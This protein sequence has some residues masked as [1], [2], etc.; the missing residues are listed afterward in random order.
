MWNRRQNF[1]ILEIKHKHKKLKHKKK[2]QRKKTF[3][4]VSRLP[5]SLFGCI[6][7]SLENSF[8]S[9]LPLVPWGWGWWRKDVWK[10]P[11]YNI[12]GWSS[13]VREANDSSFFILLFILC[14]SIG[15]KSGHTPCLQGNKPHLGLELCSESMGRENYLLDTLHTN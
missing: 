3:K 11:S 8:L 5:E 1:T 7:G 9:P 4:D 15:Q 14:I 6:S 10:A 2:S 12:N 13:S